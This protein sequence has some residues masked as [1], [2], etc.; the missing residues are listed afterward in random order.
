MSEYS[1]KSSYYELGAY[2]MYDL[3]AQKVINER[4]KDPENTYYGDLYSDLVAVT[5]LGKLNTP[6]LDL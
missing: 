3:Y 2:K 4:K 5:F 1:I 6:I